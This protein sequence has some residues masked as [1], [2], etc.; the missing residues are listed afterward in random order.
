MELLAYFDPET[1]RRQ[2]LEEH[3]EGMLELYKEFFLNRG[4]HKVASRRTGLSSGELDLATKLAIIF[5]DL[6]KAFYTDRLK[7][8]RGAPL[9][10]VYSTLA[11]RRLGK[12]RHKAP[13]GN[14]LELSMWAVALHHL[15]W[16]DVGFYS[17][18][19]FLYYARRVKALEEARITKELA[20]WLENLALE[21]GLDYDFRNALVGAQLNLR[22]FPRLFLELR[23]K[24]GLLYPAALRISRV[25]IVVDNYDA[26]RSRSGELRTF[27]RDLPDPT[28]IREAGRRIR[29]WLK[30]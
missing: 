26:A 1:G 23:S 17:S 8:G 12:C 13:P 29:E 15:S 28:L 4:W 10:E 3:V 19:Q 24:L 2:T 6:G 14:V 5:H 7:S 18:G 11:L 9:H 22:E 27:F 25:L 16:R 20:K 30:E 21:A